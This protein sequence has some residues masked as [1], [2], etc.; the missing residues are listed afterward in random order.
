MFCIC[1]SVLL[2]RQSCNTLTM[3]LFAR[4]PMNTLYLNLLDSARRFIP[5]MHTQQNNPVTASGPCNM[6]NAPVTHKPPPHQSTA[7]PTT[8]GAA[9]ASWAVTAGQ[10]S[11]SVSGLTAKTGLSV[12]RSV[13]HP[14][15]HMHGRA[16]EAASPHRSSQSGRPSRAGNR[17]ARLQV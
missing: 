9:K 13:A 10:V 6:K 1:L 8:P 11:T 2:G 16:P 14:N 3:I 4:D 15:S 5:Q 12:P 7:L 17:R